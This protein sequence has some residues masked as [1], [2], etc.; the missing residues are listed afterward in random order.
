MR[1][2]STVA[3]I[4]LLTIGAALLFEFVVRCR[5]MDQQKLERRSSKPR[6]SPQKVELVLFSYRESQCL[7]TEHSQDDQLC[8]GLH[9]S[10]NNKASLVKLL[11][12][13]KK[14]IR[15]AMYL[16]SVREMYQ[17]VR[18]AKQVNGVR[19][20]IILDNKMR[21]TQGSVFMDMLED[22]EKKIGKPP[23]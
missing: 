18:Y 23:F 8:T 11:R 16:W 13:A 14:S 5:K 9:C 2:S 10:R 17:A 7:S 12:S 15:I 19:V 1:Y 21:K 20:Q 6:K 22:G 3:Q 4:G